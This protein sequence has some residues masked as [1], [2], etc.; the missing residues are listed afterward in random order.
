MT[1]IYTPDSIEPAQSLFELARPERNDPNELLKNRFLC[2]GGGLLLVGPTGIGKSSFSMQAM[3]LWAIGK[4]CFGITPARP[5]KSLLIQAE[6]DDGDLAE[7]R[8]GVIAGLELTPAE[9]ALARQHVFV[10]RESVATGAEFFSKV[11][12]P[13]LEH[14]KP[15]LLWIDP[16]LAYLGGDT[17]SQAE[18][19][20]FLRN[21]LNPLL[22]KHQ[23]GGIVVHHTNKPPT[24][25]E[26]P[27]WK[28]GE[29]AYSGSGSAEWANWSRAVLTIRGIGLHDVFELH[30]A[31]RGARLGWR[32]AEG[33]KTYSKFIAHAKES[34]VVCWISGEP[35]L[36]KKAGRH[37]SYDSE[38]FLAL[39]PDDGLSSKDWQTLA[40]EECGIKGKTFFNAVKELKESG[41]V[42]KSNVKNRYLKIEHAKV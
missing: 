32:D 35:P 17:N 23:C 18:V 24:G 27:D 30:A 20:A 36:V 14:H 7:F 11:V 8:D 34:G 28:G 22:Q 1:Q 38:E 26:K 21:M 9:V 33:G 12:G 6:N 15:D 39:L 40:A 16:A 3:I 29:I 4:P 42:M 25:R 5:L 2:R 41:K 37:K 13:L 10:R 31:K 19:G